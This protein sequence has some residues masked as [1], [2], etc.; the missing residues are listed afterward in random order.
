MEMPPGQVSGGSGFLD[1]ARDKAG[2][3]GQTLRLSRALE[4]DPSPLHLSTGGWKSL[5]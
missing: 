2:I 1:L 4:Q 3:G 5:W